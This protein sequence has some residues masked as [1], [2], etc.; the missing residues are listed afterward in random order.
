[1]LRAQPRATSEIPFPHRWKALERSAIEAN[2]NSVHLFAAK[3]SRTADDLVRFSQS[4]GPEDLA[5]GT[6]RAPD[7]DH[8]L[9]GGVRITQQSSSSRCRPSYSASVVCCQSTRGSMS[10]ERLTVDVSVITSFLWSSKASAGEPSLGVGDVHREV[11][12]QYADA[13]WAQKRLMV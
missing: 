8:F 5:V 10:F 1:M 4:T 12:L 2:S 7:D 11:G 9:R 3:A 6:E 13:H